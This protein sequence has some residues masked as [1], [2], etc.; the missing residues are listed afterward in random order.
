MKPVTT[1]RPTGTI[2]A[3]AISR[4]R[5]PFTPDGD[6]DETAG[7]RERE[8]APISFLDG[9]P[10]RPCPGRARRDPCR[11][12]Q[13]LRALSAQ[14][15][16]PHLKQDDTGEPSHFERFVQ[17]YEEYKALQKSEPYGKR[18]TTFREPDHARGFRQ[19]Q[20]GESHLHSRQPR[21]LGRRTCSLSCST[22]ATACC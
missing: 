16:A 4:R 13:G 8:A 11:R 10:P 22:S 18:P 5:A 9:A 6:L 12:G 19:A 21:K 1:C 17:V 7:P 2:G 14:G 20:R 15:E 3:A